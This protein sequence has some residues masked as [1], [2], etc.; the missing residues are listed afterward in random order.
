[1]LGVSNCDLLLLFICPPPFSVFFLVKCKHRK[2]GRMETWEYWREGDVVVGK[3]WV[4][5]KMEVR[6]K[7]KSRE[8]KLSI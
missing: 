4:V 3:G 1:M 8:A 7:A 2:K 5:K 6:Q